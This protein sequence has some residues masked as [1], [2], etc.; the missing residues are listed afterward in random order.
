VLHLEV[1][2]DEFPLVF[3]RFA[4]CTD[5]SLSGLKYPD[6]SAVGEPVFAD[7]LEPRAPVVRVARA[8]VHETVHIYGDMQVL[9]R[10]R[11]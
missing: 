2:P 9:A 7:L 10:A 4:V 1:I 8:A 5:C 11:T 3:M 6:F